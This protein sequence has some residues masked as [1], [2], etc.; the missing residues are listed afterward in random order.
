MGQEQGHAISVGTSSGIW[1]NSLPRDW[2][3]S[4]RAGWPLLDPGTMAGAHH[5]SQHHEERSRKPHG[6]GQPPFLRCVRSAPPSSWVL[7]TILYSLAFSRMT[8]AH[9]SYR[10]TLLSASLLPL[11]L[12]WIPNHSIKLSLI[13]I[14]RRACLRIRFVFL[15]LG[16]VFCFGF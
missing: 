5:F 1:V 6:A 3:P 7:R 11:C 2:G 9:S 12:F 13:K 8:S 16:L 14:M 4:S 10:A 15:S